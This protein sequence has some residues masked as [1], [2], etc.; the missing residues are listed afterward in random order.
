M[1][2]IPAGTTSRAQVL[3]VGINKPF[4]DAFKNKIL[5]W[6][7]DNRNQVDDKL[8][9]P[10]IAEFITNAWEE[11]TAESIKNSFRHIGFS[12]D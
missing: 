4:K 6:M 9:R 8:G 1:I 10:Q 7:V 11:I 2:F 5:H 3:D 12:S